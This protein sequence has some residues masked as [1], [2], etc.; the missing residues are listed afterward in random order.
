MAAANQSEPDDVDDRDRRAATERMI[1]H[2]PDI[3]GLWHVYS[4]VGRQHVVDARD[5]VCTC[6]DFQYRESYCKHQRRVDM[7]RGRREI[8]S[9]TRVEEEDAER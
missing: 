7:Y 2:D 1:I 8:P 4:T 9:V 5:G 3:P 6:E